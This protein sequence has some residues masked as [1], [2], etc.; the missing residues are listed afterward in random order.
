VR[1]QLERKRAEWMQKRDDVSLT[2]TD[3]DIA[4]VVSQWTRIPLIRLE[5]KESDRLLKMEEQMK[6]AVIFLIFVSLV[7]VIF[8]K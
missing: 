6:K 1:E 5:Q 4:R 3:D 8:L 2:I 7:Q